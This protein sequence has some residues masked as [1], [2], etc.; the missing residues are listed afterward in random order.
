VSHL[1]ADA[2]TVEV[3]ADKACNFYKRIYNKTKHLKLDTA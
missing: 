2:L 1:I 3:G